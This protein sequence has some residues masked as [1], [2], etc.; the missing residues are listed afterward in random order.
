MLTQ[1]S[2]KW[3]LNQDYVECETCYGKN[4]HL[5]DG[6]GLIHDPWGTHKL[7]RGLDAKA[8]NVAIE[9]ELFKTKVTDDAIQKK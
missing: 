9:E 6:T 5:C 4:C 1:K 8:F 3:L 7:I 2:K